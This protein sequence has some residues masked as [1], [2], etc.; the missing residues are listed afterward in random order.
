MI[1]CSNFQKDSENLGN[2]MWIYVNDCE[3]IVNVNGFNGI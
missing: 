2:V 3:Y 1:R